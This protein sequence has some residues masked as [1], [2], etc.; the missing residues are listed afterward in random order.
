MRVAEE[1]ATQLAIAMYQARLLAQVRGD[2]RHLEDE[3]RARTEALVAANKDLESFSYSVS[4]DLRAPLRAVDG[5]ARMLEEDY[6]AR[7]DDEGR[8]LLSVVRDNAGR[9]G[10]LIDDLLAFSRLGRREPAKQAVEMTA[11]AREVADEVGSGT[12]ALIEI[13]ELPPAVADRALM[14]QVWVNLIGNAV[15]YSAKRADPRV[16]IGG[17]VNGSDNVYWVRDN[18]VGFDMRYVEKLFGVFQR[19]HGADE[20]DGTG[21]GL[22]IVQRVVARHG[23]RISAHS[24]PG[25]GARFEFCL[26][27]GA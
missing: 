7:L 21:V 15:K 12:A 22:A 13:G 14:R 10:R 25:E 8:R 27:K 26:P 5:Y 11:L 17:R 4:H 1:V 6:G 16:E 3:V 20:F 24:A 2:A 23:G 19:L 9:M 18:G